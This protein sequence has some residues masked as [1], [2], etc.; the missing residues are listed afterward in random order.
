MVYVLFEH[1]IPFFTNSNILV[2]ITLSYVDA[3]AKP[4]DILKRMETKGIQDIPITTPKIGSYLQV[5][6]VYQV[7]ELDANLF[8]KEV[9]FL[10][11]SDKNTDHNCTVWC[12]NT[13]KNLKKKNLPVMK[14]AL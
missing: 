4:A 7:N 6:I 8:I 14:A 1:C 13:V 12:R 11:F 9:G 10:S 5:I 2:C 3:D